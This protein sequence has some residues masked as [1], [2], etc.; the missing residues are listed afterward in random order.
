MSTKRT[1]ISKLA[2]LRAVHDAIVDET[3]IMWQRYQ[4]L[5]N[6]SSATS[7]DSFVLA[8]DDLVTILC[9]ILVHSKCP[10]LVADNQYLLDFV[11]QGNMLGQDGYLLTTLQVCFAHI[12]AQASNL[13][14][15]MRVTGVLSSAQ[16]VANAGSPNAAVGG[17]ICAANHGQPAA[18]NVF[19]LLKD[20]FT[21][22]RRKSDP[23]AASPAA[24]VDIS[25]GVGRPPQPATD[26]VPLF[27]PSMGPRTNRVTS[28]TLTV[29]ASPPLSPA[30]EADASAGS[31]VLQN[32]ESARAFSSSDLCVALAADAE[33]QLAGAKS[34]T[35]S[36]LTIP[37]PGLTLLHQRQKSTVSIPVS[38][39][40]AKGD[41]PL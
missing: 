30:T 19:A 3:H 27:S 22:P 29:P 6:L 21:L 38:I 32:D 16:W 13:K 4:S 15:V 28:L 1:P 5:T 10:T 12:T 37:A 40:V 20:Q 14:C 36:R 39:S 18:V 31:V 9:Y 25:I 17:D 7:S 8:A 23:F 2:C 11:D 35:P 26:S 34:V 24:A 41:A 33:D